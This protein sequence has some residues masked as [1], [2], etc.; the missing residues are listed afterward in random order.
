MA[1]TP[2]PMNQRWLKF[3][4]L[5]LATGKVGESY[6]NAG[7]DA[8]G[9]AAEVAGSRLLRNVQIKAYIAERQAKQVEKFDLTQEKVVEQLARIAF[10]DPRKFFSADGRLKP[11]HELD[12]ATAAGLAG[13]EVDEIRAGKKIVGQT[14]KIKTVNRTEALDK[15]MRF[16]GAYKRDNEQ[17]RPMVTVK[18]FTG[19]K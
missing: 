3:A 15:L 9:N 6:R 5:W 16:F 17:S 13:F 1:T 2:K 19:R 18:D 12:E 10:A 11:I 4:D 14:A 8:K 7:Y